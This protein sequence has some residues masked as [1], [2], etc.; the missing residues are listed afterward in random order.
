MGIISYDPDY[1]HHKLVTGKQ[2]ARTHEGL[3][4]DDRFWDYLRDRRDL[5]E[6]R[7]DRNH[8]V[9]GRLLRIE[10]QTLTRVP[11]APLTPGPTPLLPPGFP[12][13]PPL[14]IPQPQVAETPLIPSPQVVETPEP[15]TLL[16]ALAATL[17]LLGARMAFRGSRS[18]RRSVASS[19]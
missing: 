5:S 2:F 3:L 14:G 15:S 13:L 1:L 17:S 19:C 16:I 11:P 18:S 12:G 8:L 6:A 7:F 4:P 9:V 10:E